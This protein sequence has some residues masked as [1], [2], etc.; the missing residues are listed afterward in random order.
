MA[1]VS[2]SREE[3]SLGGI[4]ARDVGARLGY[5]VLD[6]KALLEEAQK[7]GGIKQ[8]DPELLEKQPRLLERLDRE[9]TRYRVVLRAVV[10]EA[11]LQ[12]NVVFLGRGVGMMLGSLSHALRVLVVAPLETRIQRVMRQGVSA[13]PGPKPR[14][15]AE[16]IVRR[17]DRDRAGY[18]RYLFGVDWLDTQHHDLVLNTASIGVESATDA[19]C[20]AVNRMG[21]APTPETRA[22]LEDLAL[23]SRA[24]AEG[25]G[26]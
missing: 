15:E 20:K 12:D 2:F 3:G 1:L 17:A 9:R 14:E 25:L 21:L 23:T 19:V 6:L 11:A 13:R 26:R 10:Y 8:S 18:F 7:Y 24:E 22:R 5:R 4:V 16:E